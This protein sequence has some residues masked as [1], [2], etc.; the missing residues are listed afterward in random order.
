MLFLKRLLI[1]NFFSIAF[2]QQR[3]LITLVSSWKQVVS[4]KISLLMQLYKICKGKTLHFNFHVLKMAQWKIVD[5]WNLVK[6]FLK[7]LN[8]LKKKKEK[9]KRPPWSHRMAQSSLCIQ[10]HQRT[11]VSLVY[12]RQ[13]ESCTIA[14]RYAART[15]F[16]LKKKRL[17]SYAHDFTPSV[18]LVSSELHHGFY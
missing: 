16:S 3:S 12:F 13:L 18:D 14:R 10:N 5:R 2:R 17:R 7:C 15:K 11:S 4:F 9:Q 8:I 6:I 1:C